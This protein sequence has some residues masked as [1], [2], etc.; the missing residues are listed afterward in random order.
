MCKTVNQVIF[1]ILL[2]SS[3][4]ITGCSTTFSQP[5][6]KDL[7]DDK[8]IVRYQYEDMFGAAPSQESIELE[9]Q[10]GCNIHGLSLIHI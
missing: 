9:A 7:E 10:R 4:L 6:I 8:V 2:L 3:F 5:V 1:L